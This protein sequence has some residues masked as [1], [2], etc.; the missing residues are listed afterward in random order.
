[1]AKKAIG[2]VKSDKRKSMCK[3]IMPVK[4]SKTGAY[5][6]EEVFMPSEKVKDFLSA[7][8]KK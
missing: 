4:S 7:R 5:V 6:F 2:K 1:M 3:L 8:G